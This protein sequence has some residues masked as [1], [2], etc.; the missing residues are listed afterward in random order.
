MQAQGKAEELTRLRKDQEEADKKIAD[1][2]AAKARKR[3]ADQLAKAKDKAHRALI[4]QVSLS[5]H[6]SRVRTDCDRIRVFV[7]V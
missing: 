5:F 3:A 6:V 1:K 7:V 4:K 2:E